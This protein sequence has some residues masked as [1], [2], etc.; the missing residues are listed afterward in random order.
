MLHFLNIDTL[1]DIYYFEEYKSNL[2]ERK[3]FETTSNR[4]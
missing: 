3:P 4:K 1:L 2:H